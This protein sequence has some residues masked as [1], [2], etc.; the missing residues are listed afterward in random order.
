MGQGRTDSQS[1]RKDYAYGNLRNQDFSG[2]NLTHTN[3]SFANIRGA[4][5]RNA[6]LSHADFTGAKAGL[7]PFQ[8]AGMLVLAVILISLA[9]AGSIL[10]GMITLGAFSSRFITA[11]TPMPA[12]ILLLSLTAFGVITLRQGFLAGALAA[13]VTIS[14]GIPVGWVL[15]PIAFGALKEYLAGTGPV[16]LAMACAL[17]STF[18]TA[19]ATVLILSVADRRI[20]RRIGL[21]LGG[22]GSLGLGILAWQIAVVVAQDPV[23]EGIVAKSLDIGRRGTFSEQMAVFA[24]ASLVILLG[25]RQGQDAIAESGKNELMRNL[26][27]TLAAWRGTCFE[28]A[29][30]NQANF[31]QARLKNSDF[32]NARLTQTNW[33]QARGLDLARL[34][35]SYLNHSQLRQLVVTRQAPNQIFNDLDLTGLNLSQADLAGASFIGANLS[36]GI[37]INANLANTKLVRTQ[38][39]D[40]DLRWACLTG[41]C[42]Q[43]WGITTTTNLEGVDCEFIYL[44]LPTPDNPEPYR[45]PDNRLKTF[46]VGEFA[47]FIAPLLKTLDLYHNQQVDPRAIAI[48]FQELVKNH[49]EAQLE[50]LAMEKRGRNKFLLKVKTSQTTNRSA[51]NQEYFNAYNHFK[52]MP[53]AHLNTL[54][55]AAD[56]PYRNLV[57]LYRGL[58]PALVRTAS[59][60]QSDQDHLLET[61][62]S[63]VSVGNIPQ[64]LR[65]G[66]IQLFQQFTTTQELPGGQKIQALEQIQ[67]ISESLPHAADVAMTTLKPSLR[68]LRGVLVQVPRDSELVKLGQAVFREIEDLTN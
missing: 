5:F 44:R 63:Q 21:G 46:A 11:V 18:L 1:E 42:I 27:M 45:K 53:Q 15:G 10:V 67:I 16:G 38:F 31:T 26:G 41:A 22:L 23:R 49:P 25:Y 13:T 57:S 29:T 47:D 52:A 35:T 7:A 58:P 17:L 19:I 34:G 24:I 48:A 28:N 54:L 59:T 64:S 61:L 32:R 2:R 66:L 36:Q 33:F 39:A 68:I 8:A 14:A 30:L 4:N 12:V 40:A 6:N 62:E 56:Q 65:E 9:G 50:L 60:A 43:D 37:F 3:F 20:Y 51:L 55:A